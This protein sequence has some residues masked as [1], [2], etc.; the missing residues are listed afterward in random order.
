VQNNIETLLT[1]N[2]VQFKSVR[3]AHYREA[4]YFAFDG[5]YVYV[6]VDCDFSG[7]YKFC[8]VGETTNL[9]PNLRKH[10][11]NHRFSH[12]FIVDLFGMEKGVREFA[13]SLLI[14]ELHPIFQGNYNPFEIYRTN[15]F[16][17][18]L[19]TREVAKWNES[20]PVK[21]H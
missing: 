13:K 20:R 17:R 8:Y 7:A 9:G 11:R 2:E 14:E 5:S 16:E 15:N 3:V 1:T 4:S 21:V 6:I 12:A 19:S 18:E 10:A